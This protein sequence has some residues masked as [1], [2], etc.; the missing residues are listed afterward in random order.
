MGAAALKAGVLKESKILHNYVTQIWDLKPEQADAFAKW[1]ERHNQSMSPSSPFAKT[2]KIP[3]IADGKAAG[4][5]P[6]SENIA[7]LMTTYGRSI[8]LAIENQ[9]LLDSLK[10]AK[11][12]DGTPLVLPLAKAPEGWARI[13]HPQ[14]NG[15]AVHPDIEMQVRFAFD[16]PPTK[17]FW[18]A[19]KK[20]S[21]FAK[22]NAVSA[23]LFHAKALTDALIGA[24]SMR[25]GYVGGAL[26]GAALGAI[27]DPDHPLRGA[28]MGGTLGYVGGRL[29]DYLSGKSF[30]LQ[31]LKKGTA[32]ELVDDA[33]KS[34]LKFSAGREELAVEDAGQTFYSA[35]EHAQKTAD[36]LFYDTAKIPAGKAIGAYIAAN[37]KLDSIMWGR[38]HTGMKLQVWAEKRAQLLEN[39]ARE[40]KPLSVEE[41]GKMSASFT[42]DM[43]GGLNWVQIAMESE[44]RIGRMVGEY[45][46]NPKSRFAMQ[47][48]LFAPDWTISTTRA[49]LKAIDKDLFIHPGKAA[50][51]LFRPTT[52]ADL[53]RQYIA[54]SAIYYLTVADAINY[55]M[56]G[57]HIW[58]NKDWTFIDWGDGRRMQWSKHTMEPIHWAQHPV[59]QAINKLGFVPR[60]IA[61][62]AFGTEYLS[63][64]VNALG[65]ISAG[66]RME[67]SRLGHL[68][69][70]MSPIS[71]QQGLMGQ[72]D[73]WSALAGFAGT[74]IY[75]MAEAQKAEVREKKRRERMMAK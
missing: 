46:L 15:L 54:R 61:N 58:D 8:A 51:G 48:A 50:K 40:G 11:H 16:N 14:L 30:Y 4:F 9:K 55:S 44:S 27:A 19:M 17:G 69:K 3:T 49:A 47:I 74:P 7:Y 42:N 20:L 56:S 64:H 75:G 68:A 71:L 57:H 60:E 6:K 1:F 39:S 66:P 18:V 34:G 43:F 32:S 13:P 62:Q 67:G 37:K 5:T 2:R 41:A 73:S 65:D 52:V 22:H 21:D 38:L 72:G 31:E 29:K 63:P 10:K 35:L 26:A 70:S 36:R 12:F 28:A 45:L 33:A 24:G 53:H 23:S 59:K 25:K